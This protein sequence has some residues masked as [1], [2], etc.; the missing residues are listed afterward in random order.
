L[1]IKR[2]S[3]L[4]PATGNVPPIAEVGAQLSAIMRIC[5]GFVRLSFLKTSSVTE[6]LEF[7]TEAG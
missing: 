2:L 6:N 1:A 5:F 4:P 3:D 7:S